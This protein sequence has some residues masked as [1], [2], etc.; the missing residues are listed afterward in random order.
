MS[1]SKSEIIAVYQVFKVRRASVH[2]FVH[3]ANFARPMGVHAC[4][5]RAH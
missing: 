5:G 3:R 2:V 1:L 4:I